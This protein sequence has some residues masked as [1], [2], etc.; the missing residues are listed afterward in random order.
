MVLN[1][2]LTNVIT[3]VLFNIFPFF[4]QYLE[5]VLLRYD[6]NTIKY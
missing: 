5:S 1:T 6:Y 4:V 2:Y 3:I